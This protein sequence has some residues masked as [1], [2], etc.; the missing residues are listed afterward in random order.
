MKKFAALLMLLAVTAFTVGCGDDKDSKTG[1]GAKA[2]GT[3]TGTAK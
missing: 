1:T 2:T 3:A